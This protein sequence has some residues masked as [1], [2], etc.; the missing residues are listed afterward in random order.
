MGPPVTLLVVNVRVLLDSLG[1][2][3]VKLVH[4][5]NMGWTAG[6]NATASMGL[7]VT[8]SMATVNVRL[9]LRGK[10]VK[11]PVILAQQEAAANCSVGAKTADL[12][13]APTAVA[14]ALPDTLAN[15]VVTNAQ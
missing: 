5:K 3:V 7:C 1:Q 13:R 2:I 10:F 11:G 9:V 8:Q 15:F 4:R 6:R 12:V 14:S